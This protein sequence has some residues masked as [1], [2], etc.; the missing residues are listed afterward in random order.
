[1]PEAS[2][3]PELNNKFLQALASAK[4]KNLTD[5]GKITLQVIG[6]FDSMNLQRVTAL[7][8]LAG[9]VRQ[10]LDS[11]QRVNLYEALLQYEKLACRFYQDGICSEGTCASGNFC[12]FDCERKAACEDPCPRPCVG[13]D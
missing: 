10:H 1:M 11:Q 3:S 2:L 4:V 12:C 9:A 6:Y 8:N 7:V 13:Y 5:I